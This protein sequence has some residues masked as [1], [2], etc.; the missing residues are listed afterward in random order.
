MSTVQNATVD[1][2]FN[3]YRNPNA[4]SNNDLGLTL[5]LI[6]KLNCMADGIRTVTALSLCAL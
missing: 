5:S 6:L 4:N 1:A 3:A 2:D